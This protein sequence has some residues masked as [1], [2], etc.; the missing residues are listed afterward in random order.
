VKLPAFPSQVD[1]EL[2][3][4]GDTTKRDGQET[5]PDVSEDAS[6]SAPTIQGTF[7]QQLRSIQGT[8]SEESGNV[9]KKPAWGAPGWLAAYA[10]SL[11]EAA[12]A[13]SSPAPKTGNIQTEP[14]NIQKETGNIQTKTGNIQTETGNIQ[15]K[16]GN[17]Q[18]EPGNIQKETGNIQTKTGNIQ[19]ETGNIQTETGNIETETGNIQTEKDQTPDYQGVF[20]DSDEDD[21]SDVQ[22]DLSD[23]PDDTTESLVDFTK[24][25]VDC[26]KNWVDFTKNRDDHLTRGNGETARPPA[27]SGADGGRA[28]AAGSATWRDKDVPSVTRVA[29]GGATGRNEA[30]S[31]IARIAIG[32]VTWCNEAMPDVP[33]GATWHSGDVPDV[34]GRDPWHRGMPCPPS[35]ATWR[36]GGGGGWP[37]GTGVATVAEAALTVLMTGELQPTPR[38]GGTAKDIILAAARQ[39][40]EWNRLV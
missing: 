21:G 32:G 19:T 26:T 5:L 12:A 17:I 23:D 10:K 20:S 31:D 13:P 30:V 27:R 25:R 34:L 24:N 18:T 22:V 1:D 8:F 4:I 6:G 7:L 39:I 15:T 35:S 29:V 9:Q 36:A 2:R 14:G 40:G 28:V 37:H 11:D 38:G 3:D 16:T 33:G